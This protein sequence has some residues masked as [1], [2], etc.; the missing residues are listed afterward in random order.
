MAGE[1]GFI[2]KAIPFKTIS[3]LFIIWPNTAMQPTQLSLPSERGME[4]EYWL[5]Q[6]ELQWSAL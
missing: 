1:I 2:W 4:I 3:H 5:A 6:C